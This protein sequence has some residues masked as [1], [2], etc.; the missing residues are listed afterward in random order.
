MPSDGLSHLQLVIY[1]YYIYLIFGQ[2]WSNNFYFTYVTL[3][4]SV[5]CIEACIQLRLYAEIALKFI[6]ALALC[7]GQS[8]RLECL[9]VTAKLGQCFR[10]CCRAESPASM[11]DL[12]LWKF[13][14]RAETF[15]TKDVALSFSGHKFIQVEEPEPQVDLTM[16]ASGPALVGENFVIPVSIVSKGH[17]VHS[18]ELKIN[19]VDARGG[20]L[21]SP[22]E[23][24]PLSSLTHHVELLSISGKFDEDEYQTNSD[25][26]KKIQQSFGV[27]S[28]PALEPGESWTCKLEIKWHRPKSVMLYV[29]LGYQPSSSGTTFHRVNVH[30][31]LQIEGQTPVVVSHHFMMPFRRE[32][33]LLSKL[34]PSPG[35][36]EMISL[37]LN[38]KCILIVSAR[39]CTEVP[40]RLMSMSIEADP[41]EDVGCPCSVS[42]GASSE[43]AL[44]IPGEEFKQVFSVTP[45]VDSPNLGLGTVYLKWNR[46][47]G[48]S[49]Q[50]D[51]FVLMKEKLP[52]V[53]VEKPP[54]VI[55]LECPSHV[56]LGVPFLIYLRI[57]NLTALLQ[58]V[59]Y[60]L[61]DSQ[62]FV[63]S[64]AHNDA[65]SILPK[66]EHII[67]YKLVPLGSGSQPLPRITVTSVRYSAAVNT[68]GAAATVFVF[69]SE[70]HFDMNATAKDLESLPHK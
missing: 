21:M 58:E 60:S 25:N 48:F 65:A 64:G 69:P 26:I 16:S 24:E 42:G 41:D 52:T 54:L 10:I 67:S 14:D 32:P 62:S 15:P 6:S 70:P 27:V 22:R 20:L 23:A 29:S 7:A 1:I 55:S 13:E 11:E 40:L 43:P 47:L 4:Q 28:V 33:L 19:I 30:K 63:F 8:G 68:S 37:P 5:P 44:L 12:P 57:R 59:K 17:H 50:S 46:A 9:S 56:V 66:A 38:E 61:G 34:K 2:R 45:Q 18:A 51:S 39:N 35:C 36:G 49:Q 53:T 3:W 31:S